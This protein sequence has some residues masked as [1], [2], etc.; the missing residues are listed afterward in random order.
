MGKEQKRKKT[1][2][3]KNE[4]IEHMYILKIELKSANLYAAIQ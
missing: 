2:K 3:F 4:K 1:N